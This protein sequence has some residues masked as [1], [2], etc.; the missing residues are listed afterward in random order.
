[1]NAVKCGI[2][3]GKI[4]RARMHVGFRKM[5]T[6]ISTFPEIYVNISSRIKSAAD[7]K[8]QALHDTNLTEIQAK[9]I[10]KKLR[11]HDEP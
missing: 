2:S 6:V 11:L 3:E 10:Y 8:D 4:F 1:M 7:I 5:N 9:F